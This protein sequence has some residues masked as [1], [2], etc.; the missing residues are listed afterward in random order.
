[1]LVATRSGEIATCSNVFNSWGESDHVIHKMAVKKPKPRA[2]REHRLCPEIPYYFISEV[3]FILRRRMDDTI[4][5]AQSYNCGAIAAQL[6]RH[7]SHILLKQALI[8]AVLHA[9][10]LFNYAT[11]S[12]IHVLRNTQTMPS[13]IS[14][15][16]L[17]VLEELRK[18]A[19]L[20]VTPPARWAS[21]W[22]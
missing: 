11:R 19:F 6:K 22:R 9:Y 18:F 7:F 12:P 3:A 17:F 2:E 14:L 4:H 1:M 20:N 5:I 21:W 16:R 8:A 13:V 15:R 10:I